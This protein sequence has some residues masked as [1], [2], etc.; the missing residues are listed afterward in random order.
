[1]CVCECV[2]ACVRV[3]VHGRVHVSVRVRAYLYDLRPFDDLAAVED[4]RAVQRVVG[5]AR[6]N[7]R[8]FRI[9]QVPEPERRS[10]EVKGRS[11]KLPEK[12]LNEQSRELVLLPCLM[13][14]GSQSGAYT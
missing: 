11:E 9:C 14:C 3:H 4:R 2:C 6:H 12:L 10:A 1:M 8:P 7:V 13:F 5:S